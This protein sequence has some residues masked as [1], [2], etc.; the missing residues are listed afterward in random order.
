MSR[1]VF[2]SAAGL[3]Q[4][5]EYKAV[6]FTGG[7]GAGAVG[8]VSLFTV[9]GSVLFRM[10]CVCTANLTSPGAATVE[11]GITGATATIIAQTLATDID[12]GEIWHDATPDSDIEAGTVIADFVVA[13]GNDVFMT[14]GTAN[15]STGTLL[16][17]SWWTPITAGA[18]VA[19]A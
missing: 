19:A 4:Q 13:N 3:G 10:A 12:A 17:Q 11:V 14:V 8:T 6:T 18:T 7:A 9:T 15:V 2:G 5:G 1:N 16:F